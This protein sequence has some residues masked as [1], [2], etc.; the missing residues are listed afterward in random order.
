[1]PWTIDDLDTPAVLIDLDRVEA[2]LRR[3][4][5]Y[6]D[7]HGLKL[8]PHIKTHKIPELARRQVEL[9]AVGHH[10]PEARRGRGDGGRRHRRHPAHLQPARPRQAAPAGG[11]GPAGPALGHARQC[12]G[13]ERARRR[14]ARGRPGPAGADRVRHRRRALRRADPRRGGRA[15]APGRRPRGPAPRRADDLSG[16]RAGAGDRRLARPRRWPG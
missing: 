8:R 15:G 3:A 4:Q 10:L 1:M 2:N 5:D 9:G 11:P 16:A 13:R 12:R 6:A 7:A 14:D